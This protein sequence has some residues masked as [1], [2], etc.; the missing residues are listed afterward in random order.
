MLLLG[1]FINVSFAQ[2]MQWDR[3]HS[4]RGD[5]FT[6]KIKKM[7]VH[8]Y[9]M[10]GFSNR[11]RR[12]Y[13]FKFIYQFDTLGN[14]IEEVHYNYRYNPAEPKHKTHYFYRYV[15]SEDKIIEIHKLY[16]DTIVEKHIYTYDDFGNHIEKIHSYT[17]D[18][19]DSINT[20]YIYDSLGR[21]ME[22][23]YVQYRRFP[24][25][26]DSVDF[27]YLQKYNYKY[28]SL[29]RID[30]CIDLYNSGVNHI[31][32][33]K[34]IYDSLS[35][36]ITINNTFG[37]NDEFRGQKVYQYDKYG[38]TV[39]ITDEVGVYCQTI[40]KYNTKKR[41]RKVIQYREVPNKM[42]SFFVYRYDK[43][44][45]KRKIK[46]IGRIIGIPIC[47]NLTK[48]KIEYYE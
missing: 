12:A 26:G 19:S 22:E 37:E 35:Y 4:P 21:K 1:L 8:V 13:D 38:R 16:D 7:E 48:Y 46:E 33:N 14:I 9:N 28:D 32:I 29:G 2:P 39:K 34:Y 17:I 23:S 5:L 36:R 11:I 18:Y 42:P 45:N 44:G 30:E 15:F 3:L 47:M 41:V 31:S 25:Y 43:Y 6:G 10:Q 20:E 27:R 24:L 40:F